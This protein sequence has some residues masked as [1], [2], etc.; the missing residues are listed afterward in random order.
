[1]T[2][3]RARL[4]LLILV[5]WFCHGEPAVA[6][7]S[8]H[9][10]VDCLAL[11]MYWEAK[12]EGAAGMRAVGAVVLNRVAHPEFPNT[13]CG[14]VRQGGEQPPCQF[15]WWCDGKSDR[16]TEARSWAQAQRLALDLL[17]D[18]PKDPTRGA[19]FFH[20]TRIATP[21]LRPRQRTVQIGRHIF[22]R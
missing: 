13:V 16:P 6:A 5:C 21:W 22:Y 12:A 2:S 15:S 17:A 18:R 4:G 10:A 20:S 1:M 8:H 3:V 19:L 14:V 9:E 11:A 7:D